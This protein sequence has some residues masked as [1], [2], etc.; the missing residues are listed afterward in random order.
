MQSSQVIYQASQNHFFQ[1]VIDGCIVG[2]MEKEAADQGLSPGESEKRSWRAN[3][4][5]IK[6]L[7]ALSDV[8]DTYVVF[9]YLLPRR[10]QRIDCMIFGKDSL[11]RGNVLQEPVRQLWLLFSSPSFCTELICPI[12]V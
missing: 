12:S 2:I 8:H 9:E 11:N 6:E 10:L 7:L 3:V 5:K 4:P 1:D